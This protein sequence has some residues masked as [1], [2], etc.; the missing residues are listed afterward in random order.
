MDTTPRKRS[1]IL[2]LLEHSGKSQREIAKLCKVNQSTVSRLR[3]LYTETGSL[4]PTRRGRCGR[5]R[6]TTVRDDRFL[7]KQSVINPK[8]T[9]DQLQQ[10]MAKIGTIVC[11]S[12]VRRRLLAAGRPARKPSKRQLLTEA[13]KKKRLLRA[14]EHK[15]WSQEQW[16]KV[17]FSVSI[18]MLIFQK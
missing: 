9:S 4:S 11:S 8:K 17:G 5:R 14:I 2:T 13:M 16:T 15:T 7:M 6:K 18:I 3:R 1:K 10:D 12:T